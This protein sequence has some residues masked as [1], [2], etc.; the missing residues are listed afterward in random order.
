MIKYLK[1][2]Y[3][4]HTIA[5]N[6]VTGTENKTYCYLYPQMNMGHDLRQVCKIVFVFKIRKSWE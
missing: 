2:K 5:D 1:L 4:T 3:I 6:K